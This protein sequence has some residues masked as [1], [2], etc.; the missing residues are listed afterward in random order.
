V[1]LERLLRSLAAQESAPAFEV[2]VVDND[3]QRSGEAVARRFSDCLDLIYRAEPIR[4]ISRARNRAVAESRG[5]FL[6]IIDDDAWAT[7]RWLASLD[8]NAEEFFADVVL[9][10]VT[11]LF[12]D[13]VPDYIRSCSLFYRPAVVDG[14]TVPLYFTHTNNS[15]IRRSALPDQTSPFGSAF[16][17][18]GGEDIDLFSRM[19][20]HGALVVGAASAGVFEHRPAHRANLRWALRRALRNGT[21]FAGMERSR[22]SA[23]HQIALGLRA[24]SRAMTLGILGMA[25]FWK[26]RR[27][28]ADR[29]INMADEIGKLVGLFGYRVQE[30][31][32]HS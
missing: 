15:Y 16:D 3:A 14:A 24:G 22:R 7:P 13:D 18:T 8:A 17:L 5:A 11:I 32:N 12:A 9:G 21:Q 29:L 1:G 4:G 26:D 6:A 20:D 30:Y 23:R 27:V 10:P 2:I 25:G 31:R 28:A 19:I